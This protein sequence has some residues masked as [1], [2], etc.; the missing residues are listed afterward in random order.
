MT[1]RS[2]EIVLG[3]L[4]TDS[5][6]RRRFAADPAQVLLEF[7]SQGCELTPVELEALATTDSGALG[8]FA[9]GLDRRIKRA[10][11]VVRTSSLQR[12]GET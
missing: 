5:S 9:E 1:H 12:I 7:T 6:L 8:S 3:R 2:V 11:V 10:D 4:A